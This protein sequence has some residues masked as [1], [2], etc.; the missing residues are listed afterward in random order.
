VRQLTAFVR[1]NDASNLQRILTSSEILTF[2][3]DLRNSWTNQTLL[4]TAIPEEPS[5]MR[6]ARQPVL[7]YDEGQNMIRRY[8]GWP[9]V[10]NGS[11]PTDMP[12]E[13]WSTPAG[14]TS[15]NWTLDIS[16]AANGLSSDSLG[17]F[18][19]ATGFTNSK[20]YSFGG[21]VLKTGDL[22][23]MTVLSGLVTQDFATGRWE[24]VTANIPN[25]SPYRTQA[26]STFVPGYG[27]EG[28]FVIVGGENPPTEESFYEMG[29]FMADMSVITLYDIASGTWYTQTATGDVPP[30]RSEFCAVGAASSGGTSFEV[31][32]SLLAIL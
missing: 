29:T 11:L 2:I 28:F 9:Y 20:F 24:N 23:N 16:P 7:F 19:P 6:T 32:A 5:D 25:Q 22:P 13:L 4:P 30:P 15:V 14:T 10:V 8:G 1:D 3:I 21:S 17:P 12:S 18:A 31:Y 27:D 26:K